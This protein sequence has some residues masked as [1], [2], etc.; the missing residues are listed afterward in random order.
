MIV[1]S[2]ISNHGGLFFLPFNEATALAASLMAFERHLYGHSIPGCHI[3]S[4]FWSSSSMRLPSASLK[5]SVALL[6]SLI[7]SQS[8]GAYL[9]FSFSFWSFGFLV[10]QLG[11]DFAFALVG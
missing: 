5:L 6:S 2:D 11:S 3:L 1:S 9:L 4:M 8:T 7:A 10:A